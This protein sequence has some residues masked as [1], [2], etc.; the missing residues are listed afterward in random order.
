MIYLI[1]SVLSTDVRRWCENR[2]PQ[3]TLVRKV[4]RLQNCRSV[5]SA[6]AVKRELPSSLMDKAGS[7]N[8]TDSKSDNYTAA[9]WTAEVVLLTGPI[10]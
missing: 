2:I 5:T 7:V 1:V 8:G 9:Y 4:F 6:K 10:A 3:S